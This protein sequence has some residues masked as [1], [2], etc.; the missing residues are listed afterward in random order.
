[1]KLKD[2]DIKTIFIII[3]SLGL[4]VSF[5]IGQK[6]GIDYKKDEIKN[7]QEKNISLVKE[8]SKILFKNKELDNKIMILRG[9]I[10]ISKEL[11]T[12]TESQLNSLKQRRNEI[13]NRVTNLSTN[14]VAN[15]LSDYIKRHAND[16]IR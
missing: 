10:K 3:L 14:D 11:L 2:L 15:E 12:K 9:E 6:K 1:M 13:S 7:L 8:N 5:I 16:S 4:I